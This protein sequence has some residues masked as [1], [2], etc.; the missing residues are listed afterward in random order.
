MKKR[1]GLFFPVIVGALLLGLNLLGLRNFEWR[2]YDLFLKMKPPIEENDSL[3]LLVIDDTT[4][5]NINMYPL[6][7]DFMAEGLILL[8]EFNARYTT[9]DVEFVDRSPRGVDAAYLNE[10]LPDLFYLKFSEIEQNFTGLFQAIQEKRISIEDAEVFV[11]ELA[12]YTAADMDF[13]LAEVKKIERDNDQYLGNAAR[14]FGN[15]FMTL[16]ILDWVDDTVSD[17]FRDYA[18]EAFSVKTL[19]IIDESPLHEAIDI[20]PSI[21]PVI[22]GAKGAGFPR[23]EVDPDGVQRRVDLLYRYNGELISQLGLAPLL[24]WLGNPIVEVQKTRIVLRGA[25][26]PDKGTIDISIPLTDDNRFLINWP[27]KLFEDSFQQMSYYTLVLHDE[28]ESDLAS[29]LQIM[30]NE[31]YLTFYAGDFPLPDLYQELQTLQK[32]L[33]NGADPSLIA[34][35]RDYR[36]YF[37][38][39]LGLF[40]NGPSVENILAE[41][42]SLIDSDEYTPEE[43]AGIT[44]LMAFVGEVFDGTRALYDE[45]MKVRTTLAD[46]IPDKFIFIGY[47]GTSTTDIGVNPFQEEYMNVGTHASVVNTILAGR[48]LDHFPWWYSLLL[49]LIVSVP[50]TL[51]LQKLKP[52]PLLITGAGFVVVIMAGIYLLFFFTGMYINLI[53]PSLYVLFTF[54]ALSVTKFVQ[55]EQEKGF[56]RNAFA[57][58]LSTDVINDLIQNPEK[59]NL[60][61]EKKHLTAMFTDLRGFSTVSEQLDPHDLVS[62]L[63]Q[64]LTEMSDVILDQRGTIDKF[65][66]DAILAFFGAPVEYADHAERACYAAVK[67]KS[68]EVELNKR[69]MQNGSSPAPLLTRIG[70][71][72]GD[73]VVGNMGTTQKM[74]Y[75]MMGNAVN[76]AA[77]LEGVNK[78]YGTWIL[79]SEPTYNELDGGYTVRKLDRVRVVGISEPIRLYELIE[80][81]NFTSKTTLEIVEH[82]DEALEQFENR[83]WEKTLKMLTEILRIDPEDGPAN[84]YKTRCTKYLKTPPA[85]KW[86]GVFSLTEK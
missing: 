55:T 31:G 35:Y 44:D 67:M 62:L 4:I 37:F 15:T 34:D 61:G 22:S 29:N 1:I 83:E 13:L 3:L 81:S 27:K 69:I 79:V 36:L 23:V 66:G 65:E 47:T 24:D 45:L 11:E 12:S 43:V 41:Y 19:N 64:Y 40:L 80:K 42:Q 72:T 78:Q 33:L 50:I 9:F 51:L 56:I 7:R 85:A 84:L 18:L 5:N 46:N 6:S 77:R 28:L 60:G 74:D 71:N 49:G 30:N 53:T 59:L 70:V 73:I 14:F 82:F 75:T 25:E 20:N 57:H 2:I 26:H 16:N 38:E 8:K 54:L 32:D 58:Y 10:D 86:D 52:V 39:E 48:F 76:L 21:M 68:L 63:N 17:D